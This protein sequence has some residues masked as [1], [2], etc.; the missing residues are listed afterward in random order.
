MRGTL[1]IILVLA[2]ILAA[3]YA[4]YAYYKLS[5]LQGNYNTLSIEYQELEEYHSYL[6]SNYTWISQNYKDLKRSY[7]N[8]TGR[9]NELQQKYTKLINNY[10][11][12]RGKLLEYNKTMSQLRIWLTGNITKCSQLVEEYTAKIVGLTEENKELSIKLRA[13]ENW[14]ETNSTLYK[15]SVANLT[16]Q[17]NNYTKYVEEMYTIASLTTANQSERD[18]FLNEALVSAENF[19][20]TFSSTNGELLINLF[21]WIQLNTYY[22]YDPYIL[23]YG[24]GKFNNI[25]KL[26][27][28]TIA[29]EGGDCEDLSL[30]VYS[31]LKDKGYDAWLIFWHN[32]TI[33]GHT[34]VLTK[35]N[36]EWYIIDPA[37]EWLNANTLTLKMDAKD[38][39]GDEYYIYLHPTQLSPD[40]KKWLLNNKFATLTWI[41]DQTNNEE[42]QP[43]LDRYSN[44]QALI[45][46]W[47]N[48]WSQQGY[49]FTGYSIMDIGIYKEFN[50]T[51][52]LINYLVTS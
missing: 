43:I 30:L 24:Y 48:W 44:L 29:N 17:V 47:L 45:S 39:Q 22:Q 18:Q 36:N 27:N 52:E 35:I 16:E 12:I 38:T 26:P 23:L 33:G 11:R 19:T 8:L 3:F 13:Y 25:W 5:N 14:L 34:S 20:R 9:Y 10:N 42:T 15:H 4:G 49:T 7:Y 6:K 41:D 21:K 40:T 46:D 1:I 32:E 51:T 31:A 2:L 28:E 37:G 50:T